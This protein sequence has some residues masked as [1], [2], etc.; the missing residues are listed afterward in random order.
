MAETWASCPLCLPTSTRP[1]VSISPRGL[2]TVSAVLPLDGAEP[3]SLHLTAAYLKLASPSPPWTPHAKRKN[4]RSCSAPELLPTS[5]LRVVVCLEPDTAETSQPSTL[6]FKPAERLQQPSYSVAIDSEPDLGAEYLPLARYVMF[7]RCS[8]RICP[9]LASS[10]LTPLCR[11]I[12]PGCLA[13]FH[14]FM[15]TLLPYLPRLLDG[16]V[17]GASELELDCGPAF[18]SSFSQE[19][20]SQ[21]RTADIPFR[22]SLAPLST[23]SVVIHHSG[24][25]LGPSI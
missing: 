7:T 17:P 21:G 13:T 22:L 4:I 10:A 2:F 14:V 9:L 20:K 24:Y 16:K 18:S 5:R 6:R 19:W 3:N 23:L 1:P 15:Q 25:E 8:C 11:L 12:V